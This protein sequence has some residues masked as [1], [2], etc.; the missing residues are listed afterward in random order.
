MALLV[1]GFL[2]YRDGTFKS[3]VDV[4]RVLNLPVL[5]IVPIMASDLELTGQRRRKLLTTVVV[6]LVLF[7]S[8]AALLVWR[9][10][11]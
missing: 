10:Q 1:A 9:L 11:S 7:G 2:E 4:V 5:A 6:A 8:A 3:D